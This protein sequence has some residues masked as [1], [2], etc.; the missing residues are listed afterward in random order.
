MKVRY[1]FITF[2]AISLWM[3][4]T[5]GWMIQFCETTSAYWYLANQRMVHTE[6]KILVL[7]DS[8]IVSGISPDTIAEIEGLSK[9]EV[10]YLPK[11]S[12][13]PEGILSD[14]LDV[15]YQLPKLKKVYVNLSPLNTS[16]NSV[17]DANRQLFYSFGNLS[18]Y[19]ITNPLLRKAYFSNLTDLSWK[20]LVKVFPYFGLSSNINRLVYDP[21][22]QNDI[23][24][25]KQEYLYIKDSMKNQ[26]GAWVWKSIGDD[27]TLLESEIFPNLNTQVLAGRRELSIQLWL[28]CVRVWEKQNLEIIFLRIPFSP[29]MERDILKT[30]ANLVADGLFKTITE[31]PNRKKVK[32]LDFK[33]EFLEEYQYFADL[34]HLNQKGRDA[35]SLLLKRVLFDHAHSSTKGM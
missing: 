5:E 15:I 35:F 13:Q 27:P 3:H 33:S 25:R 17:T 26:Q 23:P 19:T 29:K 11:P 6:A 32:V 4:I 31:D 9:E 12:Q 24:R 28:E 16:K 7:G 30:E 21:A 8:Q 14:S 22:A 10:L 1:F 18:K 20:L 34:T 2:L